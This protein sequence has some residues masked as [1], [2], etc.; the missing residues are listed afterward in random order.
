MIVD[1]D[2][3][4]QCNAQRQCYLLLW[5]TIKLRRIDFQTHL[6]LSC[7]STEGERVVVVVCCRGIGPQSS[8]AAHETLKHRR[9]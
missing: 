9:E 7:R 4:E 8:Q 3:E 5:C 1:N 6:V 2:E